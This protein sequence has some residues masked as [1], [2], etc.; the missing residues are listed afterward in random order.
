MQNDVSYGIL[1]EIARSVK[2]QRPIDL[3][4]GG[5]NDLAGDANEI[6]FALFASLRG[7]R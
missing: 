3:S 6:A 7:A 4:M 5:V 2:E 1:L